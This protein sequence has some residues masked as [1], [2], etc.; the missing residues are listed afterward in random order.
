MTNFVANFLIG[1]SETTIT[2]VRIIIAQTAT[3]RSLTGVT[4]NNTL[5]QVVQW[6][7]TTSSANPAVYHAN[8]KDVFDFDIIRVNGGYQVL[9]RFS[10]YS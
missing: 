4:I 9:G 7:N 2:P 1:S 3:T 8:K 6:V 5:T 10:Y